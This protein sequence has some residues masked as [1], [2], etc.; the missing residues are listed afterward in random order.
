M[1]DMDRPLSI[2][3]ESRLRRDLERFSKRRQR[4]VSDVAREAIRRFLLEEE[5]QRL[6]E[7]MRPAAEA[8]GFVTDEDVFR[9]VS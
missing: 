6:R 4:P 3:L 9:T 5:F 2:R 7:K 1:Y 8:A